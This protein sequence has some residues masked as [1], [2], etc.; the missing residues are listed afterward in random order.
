MLDA[1]RLAADNLG[2]GCYWSACGSPTYA[3]RSDRK[4]RERNTAK[5]RWEASRATCKTKQPPI[6]GFTSAIRVQK[7]PSRK[8]IRSQITE[9]T[10]YTFSCFE[11][12]SE[13]GAL[14]L[15]L[16]LSIRAGETLDAR[17]WLL[18]RFFKNGPDGRR[19]AIDRSSRLRTGR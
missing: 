1:S 3:T 9:S 7:Q 14:A 2:P 10:A 11:V 17:P 18:P 13:C 12:V 8:Q 19:I 16:A 5:Y 6:I 4:Q 15:K